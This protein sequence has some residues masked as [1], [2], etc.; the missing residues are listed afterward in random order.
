VR[1]PNA[2]EEVEDRRQLTGLDA[3]AMIPHTNING[4]ALRL[5]DH[6]DAL[7]FARELRRVVDQVGEDLGETYR[8]GIHREAFR[9]KD[10][11]EPLMPVVDEG[12]HRLHR[13]AQNT[14]EV[15][16]LL[17]DLEAIVVDA[18]DVEQVVDEAR[19]VG[20]L[21]D[22]DVVRPPHLRIDR[23]RELEALHRVEDGR[24]WIAELV[25]ERGEELLLAAVALAQALLGEHA[26]DEVRGLAGENVE[27]AQVSIAGCMDAPPVR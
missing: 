8:I 21:S 6:L 9:R 26:L 12:L 20:G 17:P 19:E 1:G 11:G 27:K 13:R 7:A 4:I 5:D 10:Q 2:P 14:A 25:R 18:A 22:D 24:E 23:R 15:D 3:H 16:R